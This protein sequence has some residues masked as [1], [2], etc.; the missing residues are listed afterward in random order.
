MEGEE[1]QQKQLQPPARPRGIVIS[2]RVLAAAAGGLVVAAAV[3]VLVWQLAFA[4]SPASVPGVRLSF[5]ND[6]AQVPP[7]TLQGS[8]AN[9]VMALLRKDKRAALVVLRKGPEPLNAA[10]VRRLER[11]L[12]AKYSDF[13]PL[14]SEFIQV[15]AGKALLLSYERTAQGRHG[16]LDTITI[17][18]AGRV[19]FVLD[20]TSPAGDAEIDH[21]LQGIIGSA[22]LVGP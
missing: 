8:P 21:E 20:T 14:R 5:P 4:S 18:P 10:A 16:E 17:I 15:Q 19:S 12:R 1:I 3:A 11:Q 13:K 2:Y 9:A 7:A 6:W 22:R